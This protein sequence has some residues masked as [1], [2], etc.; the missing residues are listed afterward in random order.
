MKLDSLMR[1]ACVLA[2][3]VSSL[4]G[5]AESTVRHHRQLL[6]LSRSFSFFFGFL[7]FCFLFFV[8]CF[9]FFVFCFLFFVFCFVSCVL[10][11]KTKGVMHVS[12][13]GNGGNLQL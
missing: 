11:K 3:L 13:Q 2:C 5:S 4:V 10:W 7:F 6:A 12:S 1:V 9:L 8:F